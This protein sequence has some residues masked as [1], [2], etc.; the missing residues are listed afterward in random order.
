MALICSCL[1]S[2]QSFNWYKQLEEI[3]PLLEKPMTLYFTLQQTGRRQKNYIRIVCFVLSFHPCK[4][5]TYSIFSCIKSKVL[6]SASDAR[7]IS[8][9]CRALNFPQNLYYPL[10]SRDIQ[11]KASH[12]YDFYYEHHFQRIS[13]EKNYKCL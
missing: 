3:L 9:F 10:I 5:T 8:A 4:H 11:L 2:Q 12:G 13:Y 6:C 7:C 1:T